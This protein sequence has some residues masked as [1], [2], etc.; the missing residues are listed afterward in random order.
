M[1]KILSYK[2]NRPINDKADKSFKILEGTLDS[3]NS[4]MDLY[5][6]KKLKKSDA[7]ELQD[8]L[9]AMLLFACAGLDSVVKQLVKDALSTVID[10][11]EGAR[12]YLSSFVE[13]KLKKE[14]IDLTFLSQALTSINSLKHLSNSMVLDI[15]SGSLQS[16]DELYKVGACFDIP[17]DNLISDDKKLKE[18]FDVRNS[19]SHEMDVDFMQPQGHQK[20]REPK[21]MKE[22]TELIISVAGKFISEVDKKL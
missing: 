9:R 18:A 20:K 10:N 6:E 22:Y 12:Q 5:E 7:P 21:E 19:I 15:T 13:R 1:T 17:T 8:L 11:H 14:P 2:M 3:C 16:K 4:F